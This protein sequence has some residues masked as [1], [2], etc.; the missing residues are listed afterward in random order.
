MK[1]WAWKYLFLTISFFLSHS[2]I[3]AQIIPS[4]TADLVIFSFNRPMQL[5][6]TLESVSK[7]VSN[8]NQIYVLYRT[9]AEQY[10][11]AYQ[12][13]Q[14]RFSHIKLVKQGSNPHQDFKP[15][16]LQCFDGSSAEYIMFAVDDDMVKDFVDITQCIEA[17][18]KYNAYGFYLRLG[19][20]IAR[21]YGQHYS[22]KMPAVEY[23][24]RD[25]IKFKFKDGIGD[26]GYPHTV[27]MALFKKSNLESFFRNHAYSSPNTLEA[28]WAARASSN[29]YAL[30]YQG[31]KI[32][33]LFINTVQQDH[34]ISEKDVWNA[35][36]LLI[37]WQ[38]GLV[39]DI[40]Q[41]DRVNNDCTLMEYIPR[42]ILRTKNIIKE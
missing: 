40:A 9:S 15:L 26:W 19:V 34:H 4:K 17:L 2:S 38:Q 33:A 18:Q 35:H 22:L 25:I 29:E 8:L 12:E 14:Q 20:N 5:Y 37:K 10:E 27:D 28:S 16:L 32:F 41:F 31:S 7:Y 11:Q 6:A 24:E 30:C 21:Q 23:V 1:Q 3:R 13:V 36:E 39:I 42:F